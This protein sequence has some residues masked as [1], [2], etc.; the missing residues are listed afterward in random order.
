MY[1]LPWLQLDKGIG[2]DTGNRHILS[3]CPRGLGLSW[4]TY[5]PWMWEQNIPVS[6]VLSLREPTLC[7]ALPP[8]GICHHIPGPLFKGHKGY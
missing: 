4:G 7:L 2:E 8:E 6:T 5:Q 3:H 1:Y